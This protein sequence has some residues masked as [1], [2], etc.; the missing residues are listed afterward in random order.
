MINLLSYKNNTKKPIGF[1]GQI[2]PEASQAKYFLKGY[3][4]LGKYIPQH[5]YGFQKY[6]GTE[7]TRYMLTGGCRICSKLMIYDSGQ[8]IGF[9]SHVDIV[10][11]L[12]RSIKDIK[13]RFK[14]LN[15]NPKYLG[16]IDIPGIG[17]IYKGRIQKMK[18]FFLKLGLKESNFSQPTNLPRMFDGGVLDLKD[19]KIYDLNTFDPPLFGN[20]LADSI[21]NNLKNEPV[22]Y[23]AAALQFK[24]HYGNL[25]IGLITKSLNKF[26]ELERAENEI[27]YPQSLF[28]PEISK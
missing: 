23:S 1:K 10:D 19:G 9:F 7:F 3:P 4:M 28:K 14:E 16:G 12:F 18:K 8:K 2:I 22:A 13:K 11:S 24:R 25:T 17:D 20:E 21:E 27:G 5:S 15:L 6:D 26:I